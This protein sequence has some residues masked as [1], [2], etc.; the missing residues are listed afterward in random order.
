MTLPHVKKYVVEKIGGSYK[1]YA[2][3]TTERKVYRSEIELIDNKW[4]VRGVPFFRNGKIRVYEIM[5]DEWEKTRY[6]FSYPYDNNYEYKILCEYDIGMKRFDKI[7]SYYGKN[8]QYAGIT[9]DGHLIISR[10]DVVEIYRGTNK[11]VA[12]LPSDRVEEFVSFSL[13]DI[14][15]IMK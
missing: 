2:I 12:I 13:V 7:I 11:L 8:D 15:K 3:F 1:G 10:G 14:Q 9:I 6:L 5:Y 4:I